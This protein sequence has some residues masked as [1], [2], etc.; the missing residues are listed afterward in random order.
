[1]AGAC[2][3]PTDALSEQAS[4]P[5]REFVNEARAPMDLAWS[6]EG[7]HFATRPQAVLGR[8]LVVALAVDGDGLA[9]AAYDSASGDEL[10][11]RPSTASY[12]TLGVAFTPLVDGGTVVHLAQH[13]EGLGD[14]VEAVDAVTGEVEWTSPP[15]SEGFS[16]QPRPCGFDARDGICVTAE[17]TG[18]HAGQWQLDPDTGGLTR[19]GPPIETL[20][21][22]PAAPEQAPIDGRY[23]GAG[24]FDLTESGEIALVLDG[25][26]VWQRPPSELFGGADVSPDY[27]WLFRPTREGVIVGTLGPVVDFPPDGDRQFVEVQ[28]AG[29]DGVTGA[30]RWLQPGDQGCGRLVSLRLV[31]GDGPPWLLCEWDASAHF[32]DDV[33]QSYDVE[34]GAMRGFDPASGTA[35]WT[36]DLGRTSAMFDPAGHLVRLGRTT[37]AATRDDGSLLGVDVETG[38]ELAVDG[39]DVGWCFAANLYGYQGFERV[40]EDL[41]EPCSVGGEAQP[42]PLRADDAIGALAG[43]VFVWMDD[44]GL[45]GATNP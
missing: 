4:T 3:T 30:T 32:E 22:V 16:D 26:I 21:R 7:V 9:L 27:G 28:T 42:T 37:F 20:V 11:R 1:M 31:V 24:L 34:S 15:A 8:D 33:A 19:A 35:T 45:H 41:T 18:E 12:V 5:E 2:A 23:L 43:G 44:A 29:I 13:P 10:W 17:G 39:D 14:V 36:V 25:E 40:G 38:E 6:T